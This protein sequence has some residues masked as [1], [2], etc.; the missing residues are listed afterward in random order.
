MMRQKVQKGSFLIIA[1][2]AL[3][4]ASVRV[5]WLH[6]HNDVKELAEELRNVQPFRFGY[7]RNPGYL[8]A[9]VSRLYRFLPPF[10]FGSCYKRSLM[11]LDLLGR[12]GLN[13]RLHL[14]LNPEN[15]G[16]FRAHAWVVPGNADKNPGN[17]S[18]Y[19]ASFQF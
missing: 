9:S 3:L 7:L 4:R 12:C 18:K 11:L 13:P 19:P 6:R 15:G 14:G 16:E 10:G 8:E 1:L 5:T 2:P 17:A